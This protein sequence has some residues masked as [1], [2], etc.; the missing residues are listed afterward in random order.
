MRDETRKK[1]AALS[2]EDTASI[3]LFLERTSDIESIE[4]WAESND[5]YFPHAPVSDKVLEAMSP[6]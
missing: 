6:S 1:L 5:F 3:E 2:V 4:A